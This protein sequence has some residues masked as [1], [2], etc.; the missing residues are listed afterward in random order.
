MLDKLIFPAMLQMAGIVVIIAEIILPSGGILSLL[1]VSVFG[2]SL[3]YVFTTISFEAGIL[4]TIADMVIIPVFV[5]YGI[6]LLA[7]SPVTLKTELSSESGVVSQAKNLEEY[8]NEPGTAL[9][10][11]RPAGIAYIKNKRMDVVTEGEYLE[12]GEHIIVASVTGNQIIVRKQ[13]E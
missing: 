12:K 8:L 3:Y 10:D 11:L 1:A 5:I 7:K 9:T 13:K 4:F 2:Y 6:K